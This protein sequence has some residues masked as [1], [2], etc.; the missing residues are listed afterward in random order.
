MEVG[1]AFA[2]LRTGACERQCLYLYGQV[3]HWRWD[4][5]G[6]ALGLGAVNGSACICACEGKRCNGVCQLGMR[7]VSRKAGQYPYLCKQLGQW[8]LAPHVPGPVMGGASRVAGQCLHLGRV[9]DI[10][11]KIVLCMSLLPLQHNT[12]AGH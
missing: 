4:K 2:S 1:Q 8:T 6:P 11:E 5:H 10:H 12:R 7:C 9:R 3:G